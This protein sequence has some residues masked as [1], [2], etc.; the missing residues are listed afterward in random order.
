MQIYFHSRLWSYIPR[1]QIL[2]E[3]TVY[4]Y[5]YIYGCL[6]KYHVRIILILIHFVVLI[7]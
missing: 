5:I 2:V 6:A 7:F 4:I 3:G 1:V